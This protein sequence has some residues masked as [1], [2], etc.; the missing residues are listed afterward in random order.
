M[1]TTDRIDDTTVST[2]SGDI[3]ISGS[4]PGYTAFATAAGA[5]TLVYKIAGPLQWEVGEGYL[6]SKNTLVRDSILSSSNEDAAVSFGSGIKQVSLSMTGSEATCAV[7]VANLPTAVSAGAGARQFVSD[8]S[9][10][11]FASVVEGGGANGVP[12]FSDGTDWRIG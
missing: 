7:V 4:S 9:A 3:K 11:T 10:T 5:R 2:G 12:V 8:A 1:Q 6:S